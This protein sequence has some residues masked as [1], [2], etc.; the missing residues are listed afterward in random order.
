MEQKS[1]LSGVGWP[2]FIRSRSVKAEAHRARPAIV[3]LTLSVSSSG[4]ACCL[5]GVAFGGERRAVDRAVAAAIELGGRARV[6]ATG[7][8]VAD[9]EPRECRT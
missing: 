5:H 3:E 9:E 7:N 1:S 8:L 2:R 4:G 6:R